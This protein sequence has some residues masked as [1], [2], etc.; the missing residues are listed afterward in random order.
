MALKREWA[1]QLLD[2]YD[3]V[4]PTVEISADGSLVINGQQY[5][6]ATY[7]Q[8]Q[9]AK[10][11]IEQEQQRYNNLQAE[12]TRR[13]KEEA[14]ASA[15]EALEREK[16]LLDGRITAEE[17]ARIE[18]ARQDREAAAAAALQ[19][20]QAADNARSALDAYKATR[21][22]TDTDINNQIIAAT[23]SAVAEIQKQLDGAI[24][25]YFEP[26]AP[27]EIGSTGSSAFV[28]VASLNTSTYQNRQPYKSWLTD[29]QNGLTLQAIAERHVGDT[30]TNTNANTTADPTAG[31]SWRF[32]LNDAKTSW[33]WIRIADNETSKALEA[34]ARAQQAAQEAS[35]KAT[36]EANRAKQ[37]ATEA[38]KQYANT[39]TQEAKN[40]ADAAQRKANEAE[41]KANQARAIADGKTRTFI[42]K[43]ARYDVGD[44]WVLESDTVHTEGKKD[45]ILIAT[46]TSTNY[47]AAHW[48]KVV[49]KGM[50]AITV[51]VLQTGALRNGRV[52]AGDNGYV[53]FEVQIRFGLVDVSDIAAS[54]GCLQWKVDNVAKSNTKILKVNSVTDRQDTI[55]LLV[56]KEKLYPLIKNL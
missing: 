31:Q 33:Q 48:K 17:A 55:E 22:K 18:Q 44:M 38:A 19:A 32:V 28:P 50:D 12:A 16:A 10:R 7:Q 36:T 34:A 54:N 15:N 25:A 3:G 21:T 11:L 45:D 41:T 20:K 51:N 53:K 37:E 9:E 46:T 4:T 30:Y 24:D 5:K 8:L 56:D 35:Q 6:I 43:P 40:A 47:N 52:I 39:K 27:A 14:I 49:S 29:L 13:A 42:A 23:N 2:V 1:S 26:G